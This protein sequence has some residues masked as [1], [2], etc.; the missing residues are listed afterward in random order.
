MIF[1]R[2]SLKENEVLR[3]SKKIFVLVSDDYSSVWCENGT[4][5]LEFPTGL[6][7]ASTDLNNLYAV[8]K[9]VLAQLKE[10]NLEAYEELLRDKTTGL[11]VVELEDGQ[12]ASLGIA[13][14]HDNDN[15]YSVP[16][17]LIKEIESNN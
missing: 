5:N 8:T 1:K 2:Q 10:R 6:I 13:G 4:T 7:T 17:E 11:S 9:S 16:F 15:W 14:W 3:M 12:L